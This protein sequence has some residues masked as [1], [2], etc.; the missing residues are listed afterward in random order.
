MSNIF[1]SL[2]SP[3]QTFTLVAATAQNVDIP[4]GYG[5]ARFT[6]TGTGDFYVA[7]NDTVVV[8][9]DSF[10]NP[11]DLNVTGFKQL[12]LKSA[13]TPTVNIIFYNAV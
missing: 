9:A 10:L 8:G 13:G 11:T 5:T 6:K 7:E 3:A 1:P 4:S 2:G 12:S